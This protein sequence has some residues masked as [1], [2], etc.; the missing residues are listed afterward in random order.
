MNHNLILSK[1]KKS[2][3]RSS[4]HLSE[5]DKNYI[6]EKGIDT[7]REHAKD[8][9]EKR[10][11]IMPINDGK[12]TPWKNHPVFV[13]QHATATCC[14]GCIQKWHKIPKNKILSEQEINF[15]VDLIINWINSEIV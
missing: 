7:I 12:Q 8:F 4:F 11:K 5:K 14:R 1:L 10:I 15:L 13:A 2:R 3:F 6:K 9:L